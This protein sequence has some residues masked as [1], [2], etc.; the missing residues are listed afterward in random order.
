[1]KNILIQILDRL[2]NQH[3]R[4]ERTQWWEKNNYLEVLNY[5]QN[6]FVFATTIRESMYL[7]LNDMISRP[8]CKHCSSEVQIKSRPFRGYPQHC[9]RSCQ[10]TTQQKEQAPLIKKTRTSN[11]GKATAKKFQE[12]STGNPFSRKYYICKYGEDEGLKK[13]SE[14]QNKFSMKKC[15]EKYGEVE[16]VNI[17]KKRQ[18]KWQKTLNSKSAEEIE[19]VNKSRNGWVNLTPEEIKIRKQKIKDSMIAQ[20]H[21]NDWNNDKHLFTDYELYSRTVRQFTEQNDLTALENYEKRSKDFHLDHRFSILE[22][23]KNNI[24]HYIV[25]SIYNLEIIPS[26]ENS[27][28]RG[29]CSISLDELCEKYFNR[30][31]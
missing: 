22:G 18:E 2:K 9:S 29:S 12:S 19:I 3:Y 17:F 11:A 30:S 5:L 8:L 1:M 14:N 31:E 6:K 7:E 10:V 27:G 16:G 20:G 15:I 28:K 21:W 13:L 23:F 4:L 25:G 24:P 26:K